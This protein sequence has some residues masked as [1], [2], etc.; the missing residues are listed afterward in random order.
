MT[1]KKLL[2]LGLV[3]LSTLIL[4]SCNNEKLSP[5][6][7]KGLAQALEKYDEFS[8]FS[9]GLAKVSKDGKL[10]FIDKTGN[11]VVPCIYT[12]IYEDY[13]PIYEGFA[14]R[15]DDKSAETVKMGFI[16]IRGKEIVPCTYDFVMKNEDFGVYD[17][18]L[19]F[20]IKRSEEERELYGAFDKTGKEVVPCI[21]NSSEFYQKIEE[22]R[23]EGKYNSDKMKFKYPYQ[24]YLFNG[25]A[26]LNEKGKYE[27]NKEA[28]SDGSSWNFNNFS[29][30]IENVYFSEGLAKVKWNNR[31]GFVD[32]E[33][34][35]IGKGIVE[36]IFTSE[37]IGEETILPKANDS[38][39]AEEYKN[40]SHS[41][42]NNQV[43]LNS[44]ASIQGY[45][46]G[47]RFTSSNGTTFEYR[48]SENALYGNGNLFGYITNWGKPRENPYNGRY[49][50]SFNVR[51][52]YTH[53]DNRFDFYPPNFLQDKE[54]T[55]YK[56]R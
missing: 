20:V 36:N 14:V 11:E 19:I 4:I 35:F 2:V 5:T 48:A 49:F 29:K 31:D 15:I 25:L 46:N 40:D 38:Y 8:N 44:L 37:K 53:T 1:T 50:V 54:N 33:G 7:R 26:T 39:K 55:M 18:I 45:L 12:F 32:S 56:L 47:K 17:L 23:K 34:Y 52:P 24:E 51:S 28:E 30:G 22:I 27:I 3:S 16:D 6:D 9:E 21:Y 43:D 42:S 13:P 10:G 41:H